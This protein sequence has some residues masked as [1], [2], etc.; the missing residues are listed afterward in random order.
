MNWGFTSLSTVFRSYQYN[1]RVN[2][3]G[4]SNETSFR[5]R[6]N[7]ASSGIRT[8]DPMVQS[9]EHK[10]L[11]HMNGG[12]TVSYPIKMSE[13]IVCFHV[14]ADTENLLERSLLFHLL[15]GVFSKWVNISKPNVEL[16]R[17]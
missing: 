17:G 13:D 2:M 14:A 15:Y 3:K 7:L 6:K 8:Q 16:M 10:P 5:F 1:E 12:W 4:S 11:G 9:R